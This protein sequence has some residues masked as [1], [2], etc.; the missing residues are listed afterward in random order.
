MQRCEMER[1]TRN[2][3][4]TPPGVV[5]SKLT[6][7]R[8]PTLG[9]R[10][11]TP[12]GSLVTSSVALSGPVRLVSTSDPSRV[13]RDQAVEPQPPEQGRFCDLQRVRRK[14]ARRCSWRIRSDWPRL[15]HW[16][17]NARH[18]RAGSSRSRARAHAAFG[19]SSCARRDASAVCTTSMWKSGTVAN[20][21]S[22]SIPAPRSSDNES[23]SYLGSC[24]V[25]D[26][27]G[28][29]MLD[30]FHLVFVQRGILEVAAL[31]LAAGLIGTWIVMRG[32]AFYAHAVG[33]A[34]FPGLVLAA[35]LGFSAHLGAAAMAL[36]V[37]GSVGWLSRRDH[38]RYDSRTALVLVA[39]LTAGVCWPATSSA[40]ARTSRPCCLEA[41]SSSAR[42]TSGLRWRP[43]WSSRWPAMRW[44]HA[45]WRPL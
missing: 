28:A 43:A 18:W 26:P 8:E 36:A 35:G 2:V 27:P 12:G 40:R 23:R 32:L 39:A 30:P 6:R 7:A 19:W 37:A 29:L 24:A 45:G 42:P 15:G 34:T 13:K 16:R 4:V 22:R 10:S 25:V 41:C 11:S 33:T 44:S 31:S 38:E 9:E 17:P 20:S 14:S 1:A 5:R 21:P 3:T